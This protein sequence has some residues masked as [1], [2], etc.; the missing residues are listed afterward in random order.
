[1]LHIKELRPINVKSHWS[2]YAVVNVY[3]QVQT[4]EKLRKYMPDKIGPG[5][6][7]ER[8]WFWKVLSTILPHWTIEY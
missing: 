2:E 4:N 1:V 8:L 6:W 5:N 7:P 3:P